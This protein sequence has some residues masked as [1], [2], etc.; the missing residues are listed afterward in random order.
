MHLPSLR[1][2]LVGFPDPGF[3]ESLLRAR[4]HPAWEAASLDDADALWV[5]GGSAHLEADSLVRVWNG[6][7]KPAVVLHLHT[8]ERP[9]TFTLPLADPRMQDVGQVDLQN[10]GQVEYALRRT[11][12]SLRAVLLQ[13]AMGQQ[14][15]ERM[16]SLSAHTYHL[17]LKEKLVGV[18]SVPGRIGIDLG[19]G[20]DDLA[21][22][23]WVARPAFANDIPKWF[24]P[25]SFA[26]CL[27]LYAGRVE[28]DLLP[29]R[30]R[31][32][33]LYFRCVPRV[34]QRLMQNVH[35]AVLS[36]LATAPRTFAELQES[37]GLPRQELDAVLTA[38]Y[39]SGSITC[40][41]ERAARRGAVANRDA[42]TASELRNSMFPPA[43]PA[44]GVPDA[45]MPAP[46]EWRP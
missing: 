30:Y 13:L 28:T 32:A 25:T 36:E 8:L 3:P 4:S 29:N 46:L 14:I 16:Q 7:D 41:P 24:L 22:A 42:V 38:L 43:G 44:S 21:E 11:E 35:Y 34:S 10:P 17:T 12:Q 31:S 19:L 20:P 27:W 18:V 37:I 6:E 23:R 5:A 9:V 33:P 45:T 15:A 39:F 26:E 40:N 2:A 1:M